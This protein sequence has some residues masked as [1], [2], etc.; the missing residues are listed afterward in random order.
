MKLY[1]SESQNKMRR[2][3]ALSLWAFLALA[4]CETI[5]PHPAPPPPPPRETPPPKP[6]AA[7]EAGVLRQASWSDLPGWRSEDPA[8]A[9]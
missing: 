8:Q 2:L 5:P 4:G 9:W 3:R 7:G 1:F 6:P